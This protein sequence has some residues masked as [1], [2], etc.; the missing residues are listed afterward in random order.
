[1]LLNKQN[2]NPNLQRN[3]E[4]VK[5]NTSHK[6]LLELDFDCSPKSIYK[7]KTPKSD[8]KFN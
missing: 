7:T 5:K 6:E 2:N 4:K 1:M 8:S 3:Q